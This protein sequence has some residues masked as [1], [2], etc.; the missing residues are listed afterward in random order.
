M[1][2]VKGSIPSLAC[3]EC[4]KM[5]SLGSS[6]TLGWCGG[7]LLDLFEHLS[8]PGALASNSGTG[9]L[10]Q[11]RRSIPMKGMNG[12]ES[13]VTAPRPRQDDNLA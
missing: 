1:L 10:R 3:T 7:P 2:L 11:R 6:A 5:V 13:A 8:T 4:N 9:C 12:I